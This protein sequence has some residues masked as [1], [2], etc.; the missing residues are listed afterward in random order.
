MSLAEVRE[1]EVVEDEMASDSQ[2]VNVD[3]MSLMTLLRWKRLV[4]VA[5]HY[6][7]LRRVMGNIGQFLNTNKKFSI[8]ELVEQFPGIDPKHAAKLPKAKA[9]QLAKH[10]KS[11]KTSLGELAKSSKQTP[12]ARSSAECKLCRMIRIDEHSGKESIRGCGE[13]QGQRRTR[14][15]K[16]S[17]PDFSM[18]DGDCTH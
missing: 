9:R 18:P 4:S 10:S 3:S 8:D 11:V 5:V 16:H 2:Q 17:M 15:G 7:R 1:W 12:L 14:R 13:H 6:Y